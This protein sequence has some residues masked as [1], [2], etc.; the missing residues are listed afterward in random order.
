MGGRVVF[1][2]GISPA[3]LSGRRSPW[4][5]GSTEIERNPAPFLRYTREKMPELR[6]CYPW[7][8]NHVDAR[9]IVTIRWLRWLGFTIHDAVPYGILR[10]PFHRFTLITER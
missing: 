10:R 8:E 5:L 7:M 1:C 2:S 4:L 6:R 3:G 9:N